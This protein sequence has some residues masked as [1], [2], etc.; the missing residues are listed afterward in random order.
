MTKTNVAPFYLG[1]GVVFF[2][3]TCFQLS[4]QCGAYTGR[5]HQSNNVHVTP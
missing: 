4:I 5:E 3:V 1:H 2:R